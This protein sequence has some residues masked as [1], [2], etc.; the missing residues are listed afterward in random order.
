MLLHEPT[1]GVDVGA[2]QQIWTHD[3]GRHRDHV[4]DLRQL[5]LRAAGDDLRPGRGDR[6]RSPG[7][8]PDRLGRDE[9]TDSRVLP[10][11]LG[12][13]L[14]G[15]TPGRAAVD[16]PDDERRVAHDVRPAGHARARRPRRRPNPA[17]AAGR[18]RRSVLSGKSLEALALPIA[19]VVRDR[20]LRRR[21]AR[22]RSCP[23]RTSPRSWP[24][25]PCWSSC[26]SRWSSCSPRATTTCRWPRWSG[27]PRT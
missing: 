15:G 6:P 23:R 20:H 5:R 26:R 21:C 18:R 22:A 9:G 24:R 16:E 4:D 19:W 14:G 1:Q 10:A 12:R 11:Q 3:P 13:R 2:R 27:C 17:P 25:R 8:L 7:R